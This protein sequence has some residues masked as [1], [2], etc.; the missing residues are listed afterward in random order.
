MASVAVWG[1]DAR[2]EARGREA[3]GGPGGWGHRAGPV[4]EAAQGRTTQAGPE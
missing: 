2:D 4:K 1:A 3:G